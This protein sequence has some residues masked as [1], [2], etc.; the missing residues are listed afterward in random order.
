[1]P[2]YMAAV[3]GDYFGLNHD[4]YT[5]LPANVSSIVDILE[6]AGISWGSYMEGMP[7]TGFTGRSF[8]NP[9]TKANMYV[10]KHNPLVLFSSVTQRPERLARIKNM[11]LF[12]EDL[13]NERLPQ[14]MFISPNMTNDG[15][16]TSVTYAGAW[17]RSF[18]EPLLENEYFM[19]VCTLPGTDPC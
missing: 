9:M 10:R 18:L 5:E 13:V 12:H 16:D 17:A 8:R 15:H 1:M 19:K 14:W 7:Y 6:D 4:H 11:T 3:G 2:N